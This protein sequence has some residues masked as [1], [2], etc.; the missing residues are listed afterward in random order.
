MFI[1]NQ[2]SASYDANYPVIIPGRCS[3]ATSR[4]VGTFNLGL[5]KLEV[6][7]VTFC[8]NKDNNLTS[9]LRGQ[10]LQKRQF[11]N[12]E[13]CQ[14]N[15]TLI[16]ARIFFHLRHNYKFYQRLYQHSGVRSTLFVIRQTGVS[17]SVFF[18]KKE[19]S[20]PLPIDTDNTTQPWHPRQR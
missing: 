2:A 9:D 1:C 20:L 19:T 13:R 17:C 5:E 11:S 10:D 18:P 14:V 16:Q 8:R 7:T 12:E 6:Y 15:E 4:D 3:G